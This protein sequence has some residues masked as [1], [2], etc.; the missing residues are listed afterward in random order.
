VTAGKR[1]RLNSR[2]VTLIQ[3]ALDP[4][5]A[6]FR[7]EVPSWVIERWPRQQGA[8]GETFRELWIAA[9][10]L[11]DFNDAIIGRIEVVADIGDSNASL[12]QGVHDCPLHVH[13]P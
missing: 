8:P 7:F 5:S 1:P 2:H 13:G 6:R 12:R 4:A 11:E 3:V 10:E 9:E